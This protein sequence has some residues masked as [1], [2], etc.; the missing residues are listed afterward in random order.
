MDL[1]GHDPEVRG[2]TLNALKLSCPSAEVIHPLRSNPMDSNPFMD[3]D[4]EDWSDEEELIP[5]DRRRALYV[6]PLSIVKSPPASVRHSSSEDR[7]RSPSRLS[8]DNGSPMIP[9]KSPSRPDVRLG[10]GGTQDDLIARYYQV[11][12][13][14]DALRSQLQRASVGPHGIPTSTSAI[15]KS[16]EKTLMEELQALRYNIRVWTDAYF[17]G[18]LTSRT[19]RPH[20]HRSGDLFGNLS[21]NYQAYLKHSDD[22]PLLIQAYVWHKLQQR[23]FS[24]LLKGCGYVWAGKLG[25]R[26][27]RPI[28]D[29]LRKAVKNEA[30]ASAYHA[31]RA[32]TVELLIPRVDNQWAPVFDT[33]PVLKSMSRIASKLRRKLRPYS[34]SSLRSPDAKEGLKIIVSAAVALDLKM[35][36]QRADYRFVTFTGSHYSQL[37]GFPLFEEEMEDIDEDT[38]LGGGIGSMGKKGRMVQVSIAPALERCGNANGHIFEQSFIMLKADV[39]CRRLERDRKGGRGRDKRTGGTR[40]GIRN[41]WNGYG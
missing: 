11:T 7:S 28:N 40:T 36:R 37:Y 27:L 32:T 3:A 29:T 4:A 24:N 20:L 12:R 39:S 10:S 8:L 25:D 35:K 22:R 34:T 21:D 14:R 5:K 38:H 17:S 15:Y 13:E 33:G 31:W 1:S 2:S 19:K 30:Q 23:V 9:P 41:L 26:K 18:P 6:P 16:E